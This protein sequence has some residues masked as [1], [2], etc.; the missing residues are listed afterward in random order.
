MLNYLCSV[1]FDSVFKSLY[2]PSSIIDLYVE[3]HISV[4]IFLSTINLNNSRGEGNSVVFT[5]MFTLS[6]ILSSFLIL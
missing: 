4:M 3:N 5:H 6:L 1:G 2:C